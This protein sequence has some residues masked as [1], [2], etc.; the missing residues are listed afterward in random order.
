MRVV[1]L[2]GMDGT[3][4]LFARFVDATPVGFSTQVI[5]FP[6]DQAFGYAELENFVRPQLPT[7]GSWLLLGESFSGPLTVRLAA[8]RPSGLAGV[9]LAASFVRTP[10]IVRPARIL[11]RV[12]ARVSPPTWALKSLLTGGDASLAVDV[13]RALRSVAPEAFARRLRAIADVD[14]VQSLSEVAAPLLVLRATRDR[15]IPPT[16][17]TDIVDALPTAEVVDC[18]APHLVLQTASVP[19]WEAIRRRFSPE[20]GNG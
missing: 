18:A 5:T 3:G 4:E 20:D 11:A 1:L 12:A 13:R 19:A 6:R 2:P 15:L 7:W 17:T 16:A 10:T 14:V 8:E 9:V